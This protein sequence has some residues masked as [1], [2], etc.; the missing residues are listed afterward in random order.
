MKNRYTFSEKVKNAYSLLL[1]R[2]FYPEARL[3]RRPVYIRGKKSIIGG[4]NL[5]LGYRCRFDLNGTKES[6]YI[7]ENCQFGDSTHI[8][9]LNR[10]EIGDNVLIASKVFIS[11]SSHGIYKG[12]NCSVPNSKPNSR[13][14]IKKDIHIGDNVWIGENVVILPGAKIGNG[15]IIGANCVVTKTIPKNCV[16]IGNNK[17]IKKFNEKEAYWEGVES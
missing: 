7:G 1:T 16:V 11:D 15:C 6:L 4:K 13:K 3:I 8:V 17:V 12:A 2:I 9:A 10:V 14:L 5:T